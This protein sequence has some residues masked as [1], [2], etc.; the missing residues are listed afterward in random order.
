MKLMNWDGVD[1]RRVESRVGRIQNRIYSASQKDNSGLVLFLQRILIR[2]LDAKLLAV[3][4]VTTENKGRNRPGVDL[5]TSI[6]KA[7]LV[8]SLKVD[9][10]RPLGIR[11]RGKQALVLMA[12]EPQWEAR[13]EPNSYGFRS[14][15]SPQDA[16]EAVFSS[17]RVSDH[18]SHQKFIV[19][20]D[21]KGCFDNVDHE[22][23]ISKL[24]TLPI[25]RSQVKTWLKAGFLKDLS[26]NL[27]GEIHPGIISPF[28]CNVALHGMEQ[29]LK[30]WIVSQSWPY[31]HQSSRTNKVKSISLIRFADDFVII[32]PNKDI[33][34]A[35]KN[36]LSLWLKTTSKLSFNEE[37]TSIQSS[38]EGFHFLGFSFITI[39]RSKSFRTKIYPSEKSVKQL[40][41][42]V[43]DKCRKYRAI[44]SYDLIGVLSPILLNWGNYFRYCECKHTFTRVNFLIFHILR[45]WVFRRDSRH[46]RFFIKEKY[47]PSGKTY[48]YEGRRYSDNWVLFGQKSLKGNLVKERYLPRISWV[49]SLKHLKVRGNASVFDGQHIYWAQRL[50]KYGHFDLPTRKLLKIQAGRCAICGGKFDHSS[51]LEV[52]H[53]IPLSKGGKDVYSNLQLLHRHCHILKT[54]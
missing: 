43:G 11:D 37:K 9:G 40:I 8:C 4:R 28:L 29:H 7:Q 5:Q 34:L 14:G 23:L 21:L 49:S 32:H 17:I 46:G 30:D 19:D 12:L 44:S 35:A 47:F 18:S 31:S 38:T 16:V 48:T 24:D 6:E 42:K 10:R 51:V 45:S 13:F 25:I 50:A 52:D 26:Y 1:W 15:R 2:S 39:R 36:E 27:Y 22:Y 54:S 3:R 33:S 20:G 41:K 53:I